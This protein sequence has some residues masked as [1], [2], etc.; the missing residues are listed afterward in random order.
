MDHELIGAPLHEDRQRPPAARVDGLDDRFP[1]LH[2]LV[3]DREDHI[4]RAEARRG[5]RIPGEERPHAGADP[6][7]DP[8]RPGDGGEEHDGEE[9]VHRRAR[10]DDREALGHGFGPERAFRGDVRLP[11]IEVLAGHV[12]VAPDGQ[13]VERVGR[14][15]QRE[16]PKPGAEADRKRV[17]GD[18]HPFGNE[19]VAQ[20]VH[21]DHEFQ[22]QDREYERRHSDSS[23]R[24]RSA[25]HR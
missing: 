1:V 10:A 22:C 3:I 5:G 20:F 14:L 17:H 2:R 9:E 24:R 4:P 19:Q 6:H 8:E 21:Q 25:F 23:C 11:G 18:P 15:P 7:R 16:R 13:R 12:D